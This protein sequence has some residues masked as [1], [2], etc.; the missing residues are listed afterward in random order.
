[1]LFVW[2]SVRFFTLSNRSADCQ[3]SGDSNKNRSA[4]PIIVGVCAAIGFGAVYAMVGGGDNSAKQPA[5][6][7]KTVSATAAKPAAP[8]STASGL[9]NEAGAKPVKMAASEAPVRAG[10][11][12]V[13]GKPLNRGTM[14][15][16]VFK[17]QPMKI[18]KPPAFNGPDGKPMTLLDFKGKVVLL[19]LWATWC[20]PCRKEMPYLN[21]LQKELGSDQFEVVAVSV[22]RGSAAKSKKFLAD[23]G[24]TALGFY[25]DPTAQAGF[26]LMAIGM[27][28]TL[29]FDRDG[30]EIGR[31]VGPAEWH[32]KDAKDLIRAALAAG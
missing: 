14:T 22:D 29:L 10:L 2:P 31:L 18:S 27:P 20:A 11:R 17:K 8:G 19:N 32:S 13:D 3:M 6:E 4:V 9:K 23:V 25:H 24:A 16:F 28:T 1:V 21:Q 26:A 5:A 7:N 12:G 15:T 30:R